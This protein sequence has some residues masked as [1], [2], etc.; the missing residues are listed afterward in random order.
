MYNDGLT[1]RDVESAILTGWIEERQRSGI[2]RQ[3]KYRLCG[4]SSSGDKMEVIVKSSS[5]GVVVVTVY[6]L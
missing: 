4:F 3:W 1:L 2:P 6:L 5:A